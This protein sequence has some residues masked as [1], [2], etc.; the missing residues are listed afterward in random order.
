MYCGNSMVEIVKGNKMT[1]LD[2]ILYILS[3][4]NLERLNENWFSPSFFKSLHL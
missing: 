1:F 2:P 3:G 4:K